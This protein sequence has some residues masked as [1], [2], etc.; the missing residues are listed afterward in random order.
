MRY[1]SRITLV[2]VLIAS[3]AVQLFSS[4]WCWKVTKI[5]TNLDIFLPFFTVLAIKLYNSPFLIMILA[6]TS[7]LLLFSEFRVRSV[8]TP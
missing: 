4:A 1:A 7:I 2:V 6:F 8:V 3:W 5:Y